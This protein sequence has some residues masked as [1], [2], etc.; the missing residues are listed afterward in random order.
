M[1]E[2][3]DSSHTVVEDFICTPLK[4]G[5]ISEHTESAQNVAENM[6]APQ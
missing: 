4:C 5:K 6:I 2:H 1:S 3:T